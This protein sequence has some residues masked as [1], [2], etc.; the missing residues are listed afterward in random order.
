MTR[1]EITYS[2]KKDSYYKTK[3]FN[4]LEQVIEFCKTYKSEI[5]NLKVIEIKETEL[6]IVL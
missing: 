3:K 1:Y 6:Y 4:T 5:H 2:L